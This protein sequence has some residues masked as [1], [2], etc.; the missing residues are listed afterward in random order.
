S[1][2]RVVAAT[3]MMLSRSWLAGYTG[4][5]SLL[6]DELPQAATKMTPACRALSMASRSAAE[7]KV[8]VPK[9]ALMTFAPLLRAKSM[10][11]MQSETTPFPVA[12]INLQAMICTF[13]QT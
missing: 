10:H 2:E 1:S 8:V 6:S 13:Q 11:L 3:E 12:S 9:L 4:L 7:A 5:S